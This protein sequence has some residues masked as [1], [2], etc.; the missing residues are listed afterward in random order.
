MR[1]KNLSLK[2]IGPFNTVDMEFISNETELQK[3]PVIVI[4]GENGTGKTMVLDAIRTLFMGVFARVERDI[5]TSDSF[6]IKSGIELNGK[7]ISFNTNHKKEKKK[8]VTSHMEINQLFHAQFDPKYKKDFVFEY[9]T[10]KLS[11]DTFSIDSLVTIDAK[12][13]LDDALSG[14]HKNIDVTK[15]ISYFDYL[16]DSKDTYEQVLGEKMYKVLEEIINISLGEGK[17]SHISRIDLTPILIIKNKEVSIDKLSS[18]NLYLIQRF[19][20]ILRQIYS[21]CV[22][23]RLSASDYNKIQGVVLIDEAENHLHPKWQKVFLNNILRLFPNLQLIVTTHS[24][25]IVSSVENAKVFVCKSDTEY[26]IVKEETDLYTN[27]PVEEILMSPLFNTCNFNT[28]ITELLRKRKDALI[29]KDDKEL[30]RIEEELLK[31]NPEYFNYLKIEETI[32]SIR[33]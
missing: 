31:I 14:I 7:S 24:P 6:L 21:I 10:S 3:P 28:E 18:G 9:W 30:Q 23:N 27:K 4:T 13:Y 20:S 11:N 2:N 19:T 33:K 32:K 25:F 12:K 16:K 5:A 1:L 26:S 17:L 15:T 29:N 8:F 22:L